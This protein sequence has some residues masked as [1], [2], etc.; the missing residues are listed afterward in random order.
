MTEPATDSRQRCNRPGE[1][2]RQPGLVIT[3]SRKWRIHLLTRMAGMIASAGPP[4]PNLPFAA[5]LSIASRDFHVSG[6]PETWKQKLLSVPRSHDGGGLDKAGERG[7]HVADL[8]GMLKTIAVALP[9]GVIAHELGQAQC[10][11]H[12]A[13][14]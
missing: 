11:E 10:T 4:I 7:E 14:A 13:H 8:A 5:A 6:I 3:H 9:V 1:E 12:G 2:A